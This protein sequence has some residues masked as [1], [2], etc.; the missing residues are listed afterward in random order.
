MKV[1]E[2]YMISHTTM[3]LE[4]ANH[5]ELN[6]K[7]Y[8]VEGIFYTKQTINQLLEQA[9][10]LYCTD[11]RGRI[12]AVRNAF[13]YDRKT[14][15]VISPDEM[16]YAIPTHSPKTYHCKWIFPDHVKDAKKVLRHLHIYFYNGLTLEIDIS[17][18]TFDTQVERARNSLVHFANIKKN[19]LIY[20]KRGKYMKE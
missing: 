1:V 11:Y 8:D 7:I 5:F 3:A 18:K 17:K 4:T 9:C 10:G 6:T 14:P 20:E 2:N 15:L 19:Q 12:A 16:L 13:Q